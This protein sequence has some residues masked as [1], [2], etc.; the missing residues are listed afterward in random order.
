MSGGQQVQ[1]G[2]RPEETLG[3][4]YDVRLMARL[5]QFVKPHWRLLLLS[6]SLI[7][8]TLAFELY[9]PLIL[10]AAIEDH[11]AIDKLDGLGTL[12]LFYILLVGLQALSQYAQ[13]YSLQLLGQRSMHDLRQVIYKHVT[14]QR[15]AFFD[16]MPIG[17]LLTRMT[18][19]VENINE[20]FASGVI[21]LVADFIKL[22]AIVVMMLALDVELTLM[23]FLVLP[24]LVVVI[25]YARRLMRAS[26]RL[27]RVKVAAL[28]SFAQEH[29]SGLRVVQLF[30]RERAAVGEYNE[31]NAEHRDAYLVAIKADAAMYALV[32]GIGVVS[33]AAIAWYAGVYMVADPATVALIVAFIEYIRKFF[34]P[35][36]DFSAKYTVMQSAMAASERIMSL[37]DNDEPDAP[38]TDAGTDSGRDEAQPT[39][40][41]P[42][43]ATGP[44]PMVRFRDVHFGYRARE[45]V[46]R[47]VSFDIRTGQTVAVVGATGSGKSTIIKLL[48]RLYEIDKGAILIEGRDVRTM[49][50][51]D[52]RRRITVVT[53]DVFLF[54]GTVADNIRLGDLGADEAKL[55]AALERVGGYR[56]LERRMLER[57]DKGDDKNGDDK[58]G[59]AARDDAADA[60][61][62]PAVTD[63]LKLEVAERASNLSAGE[64]QLVSFAR[65][66][67]RDPELLVLDEATAHV[68]PEAETSIEKGVA[69]LMRGR[70]TLV[71]A[72]RLS[73]IRNA[74]HILVMAR[75]RIVEQGT[76][77]ELV[78]RGGVYAKLERTFSRKD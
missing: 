64:R 75:G 43:S 71:I 70:T 19:D 5:W 78:A 62:E 69:E 12:A 22:I 20:M 30:A 38:V 49:E 65:A 63:P 23:T 32:E 2:T 51:E 14:G 27:I 35:I 33:I 34:I 61:T 50:A 55:R 66:L 13:M 45:Q 18:N 54:A 74:D 76:H 25:E 41:A 44:A 77:D 3:K 59:D 24:V 40:S 39:G 36:R 4:A 15:A 72:H 67:V 56:I 7:P 42:G 29:L 53:Q 11:I 73:T 48:A 47:G 8:V 57:S 58:N 16:R 31:I 68:D 17:R 6:F 28:N 46:L 26:F 9:Q 37:L 1:S 52:L 10:K 21:T 60:S